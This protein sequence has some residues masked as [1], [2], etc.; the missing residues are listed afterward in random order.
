MMATVMATNPAQQPVD[1]GSSVVKKVET[2]QQ[3]LAVLFNEINQRT[4]DSPIGGAVQDLMRAMSEVQRHVLA[5][6][7]DLMEGTED[8]TSGGVETP[9]P[10]QDLTGGDELPPDT[11]GGQLPPEAMTAEDPGPMGPGPFNEAGRGM[12][13]ALMDAARRRPP[14]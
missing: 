13:A 9:S 2:V 10:D 7:P 12:N 11:G 14:R 5:V 1:D 8:D 4:P 3:G 6:G